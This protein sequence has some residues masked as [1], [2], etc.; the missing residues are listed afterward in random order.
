M[1]KDIF[2][3]EITSEIVERV[4]KLHPSSPASWG[5]M[6][7]NEMMHHCSSSLQHIMH[8]KPV[9]RKATLKQKALRLLFLYFIPKFPQGA[10]TRKDID[11]KKSGIIAD[12]F[13]T[14]KERFI[15]LLNL[16]AMQQKIYAFHPTFGNL[17]HKQWGIFTWMHMD[18]HLRQFNV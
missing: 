15:S 11:I 7:V 14:E 13:E 10:P 5:S 17:T 6:N 1:K 18:H 9:D 8:A 16:F 3:Q 12:D 2:N 4:N